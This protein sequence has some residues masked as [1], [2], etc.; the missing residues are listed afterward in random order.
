MNIAKNLEFVT[1][2]KI[3]FVIPH[4]TFFILM[5]RGILLFLKNLKRY[6]I[7]SKLVSD[8]FFLKSKNHE[9]IG[10]H[11]LKI[12]LFIDLQLLSHRF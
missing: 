2:S 6:L 5:I 8:L 11:V 1:I 9:Q 7:D 12:F 3:D 10:P 4:P